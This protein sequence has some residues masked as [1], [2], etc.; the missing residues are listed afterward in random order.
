MTGCWLTRGSQFSAPRKEK[1]ISDFNVGRRK[2]AARLD[3]QTAMLSACGKAPQLK[4]SPDLCTVTN[5]GGLRRTRI[6]ING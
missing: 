2:V 5:V 6:Q 1:M 4:T 3:A